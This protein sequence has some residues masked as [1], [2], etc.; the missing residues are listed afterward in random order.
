MDEKK[1]SKEDIK[2]KLRQLLYNIAKLEAEI[3]YLETH[4]CQQ[5]KEEE[6]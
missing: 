2:L 6:R 3:D 1:L 5:Q 4:Q